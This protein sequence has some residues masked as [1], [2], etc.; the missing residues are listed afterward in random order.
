MARKGGPDGHLSSLA[1]QG[2]RVGP[3]KP[4]SG[5]GFKPPQ[6]A[7]VSPCGERCGKG[8]TRFRQ[9]WCGETSASEPLMKCRK[10]MDDVKTGGLSLTRDKSGGSPDC[11]PDGIRHEGGVT[12]HLALARN[13]GNLSPRCQGR[14]PSGRSSRGREYRCAQAGAEL[15]SVVC[16]E[17]SA[18]FRRG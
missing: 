6:A 5:T 11:R 15:S 18:L 7:S 2:M 4:R 10:R 17:R 12:L 3:S 16:A 14:S 9:V 8:G 13:V 1:A